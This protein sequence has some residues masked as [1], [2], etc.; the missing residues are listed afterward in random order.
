MPNMVCYFFHSTLAQ[1]GCV[2]YLS[3]VCLRCPCLNWFRGRNPFAGFVMPRTHTLTQT[4][5]GSDAHFLHVL[6][7]FFF[8]FPPGAIQRVGRGGLRR[9]TVQQHGV[10]I[11]LA[12]VRWHL[13]R[14]Q[15]ERVRGAAFNP[16]RHN[17]M[18][19]MVQHVEALNS[20]SDSVAG[21]KEIK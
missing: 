9:H 1:R 16:E 10:K 20:Y 7:H 6:Q 11:H 2:P 13:P 21:L 12:P 17:N 18:L 15:S 4:K 19:K 8:F 14:F 3:F 5:H